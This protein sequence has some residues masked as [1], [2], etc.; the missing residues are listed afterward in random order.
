M[1]PH[2]RNVADGRLIIPESWPKWNKVCG[3]QR[4]KGR[5]GKCANKAVQG[6]PTC[7]FHGSGGEV[8][9][10]LGQLRYLAWVICGGPQDVPVEQACR[11]AF[12]VYAEMIMKQGV[13]TVDQQLK[14]ALWLTQYLDA[15]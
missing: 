15:Q 5:I 4:K 2:R 7:R 13:G 12:A 8:N 11:I 3:A 6:M 1:K 14:A 10:R 9:R